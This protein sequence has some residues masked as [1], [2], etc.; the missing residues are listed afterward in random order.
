MG[1][2]MH[3]HRL[4]VAWTESGNLQHFGCTFLGGLDYFFFSFFRPALRV[5]EAMS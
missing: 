5:S 4:G 2:H 3:G 1:G